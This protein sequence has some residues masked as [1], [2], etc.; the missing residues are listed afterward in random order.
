MN[1]TKTINK[2]MA[3]LMKTRRVICRFAMV[4]S[5]RKGDGSTRGELRRSPDEPTVQGSAWDRYQERR[6][7][8]QT[9]GRCSKFTDKKAK[10]KKKKVDVKIDERLL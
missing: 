1:R 10:R 5:E 2:A 6:V 4:Q 3:A 7:F 8:L 9:N